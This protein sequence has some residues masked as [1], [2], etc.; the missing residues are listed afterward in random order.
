MAPASLAQYLEHL[1]RE[2]RRGFAAPGGF[3]HRL[4]LEVPFTARSNPEAGLSFEPVEGGNP[5][6]ARV[7]AIHRLRLEW[8]PQASSSEGRRARDEGTSPL[9]VRRSASGAPPSVGGETAEGG[10]PA[11]LRRRLE[12]VFAGPPGFGTGARAE[13]LAELLSEFGRPALL[14]ALRRDWVTQFDTGPEA[15]ASVSRPPPSAEA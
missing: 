10:D 2:V 1:N 13:I 11:T 12:M 7:D 8:D 4:T 5:G 14:E 15:S 6:E 9:A 3:P